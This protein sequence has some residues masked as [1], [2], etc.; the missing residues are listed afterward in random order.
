MLSLSPVS[1]VVLKGA[2][3]IYAK[4]D[5]AKLFCYLEVVR[6]RRSNLRM[7]RVPNTMW[8]LLDVAGR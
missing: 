1:D 8:Y 4:I 7:C 3:L 6:I 5:G 2:S